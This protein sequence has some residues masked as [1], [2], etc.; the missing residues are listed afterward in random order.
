MQLRFFFILYFSVFAYFRFRFKLK[1]GNMQ[2][3]EKRL[4]SM[5]KHCLRSEIQALKK[6]SFKTKIGE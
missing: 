2:V 5:K 3:E 6:L 4:G 1:T